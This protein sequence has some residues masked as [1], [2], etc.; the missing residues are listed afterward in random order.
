MLHLHRVN[1]VVFTLP[2]VII[3]QDPDFQP[4]VRDRAMNRTF[5][6]ISPSFPNFKR[7]DWSAFFLVKLVPFIPSFSP[8]MLKNTIAEMNC[9]NYHVV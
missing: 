8:T 2:H 6:I 4:V 7:D 9:T 1:C 3:S 5:A